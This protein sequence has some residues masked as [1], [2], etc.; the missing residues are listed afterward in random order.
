MKSKALLVLFSALMTLAMALTDTKAADLPVG[1]SDA[2]NNM[3]EKATI[4]SPELVGGQWGWRLT[5][6]RYI[7]Q[8]YKINGQT[9]LLLSTDI[10]NTDNVLWN[11][12]T[13]TGRHLDQGEYKRFWYERKN[14]MLLHNLFP[15]LAAP[16]S[17]DKVIPGLYP[18][19]LFAGRKIQLFGSPGQYFNC[20]IIFYSYYGVYDK[21]SR[22]IK[23]FY[24]LEKLEH[25]KDFKYFVCPEAETKQEKH[26]KIKFE[27]TKDIFLQNY[28]MKHYCFS[29]LR[30]KIQSLLG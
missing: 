30:Q 16:S 11:P 27:E 18:A 21:S 28:L 10:N 19:K 7:D 15:V 12:L 23:T 17:N 13:G 6:Y 26:I 20:G 8:A 5:K 4:W 1:D 24:V 22:L 14:D 29:V 25:P 3:T 9:L 2:V